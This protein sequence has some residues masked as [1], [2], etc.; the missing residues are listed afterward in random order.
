VWYRGPAASRRRRRPRVPGARV[1]AGC[2]T[3]ESHDAPIGEA[4]RTGEPPHPEPLHRAP[5]DWLPRRATVV[6][7]I[8][9]SCVTHLRAAFT[10]RSPRSRARRV[11][12]RRVRV[13][14]RSR[15]VVCSSARVDDH[16]PTTRRY[17]I[18]GR[19]S[20]RYGSSVRT[21][22]SSVGALG[23]AV[24][25]SLVDCHRVTSGCHSPRARLSVR[26][27]RMSAGERTT[28]GPVRSSVTCLV[29]DCR[30]RVAGCSPRSLA[31]DLRDGR[32][33]RPRGRLTF[34]LA[35]LSADTAAPVPR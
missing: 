35:R 8:R 17:L 6:V 7:P 18:L 27:G 20:P 34:V 9:S 29:L 31:C 2:C 10:R 24:G 5:R 14:C 4:P 22:G 3:S 13:R 30:S 16:P 33:S 11:G 21:L 1:C 25:R 23:L 19:L 32:L 15:R 12:C 28:A 26:S